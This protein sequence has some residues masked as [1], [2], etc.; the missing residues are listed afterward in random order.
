MIIGD[1]V[2]P[3]GIKNAL[4]YFKNRVP[5][6]EE[7]EKLQPVVLTQGEVPWDPCREDNNSLIMNDFNKGVVADA[8]AD[9]LAERQTEEATIFK[10]SNDPKEQDDMAEAI[11]S[12]MVQMT[13]QSQK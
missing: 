8:E 10:V 7:I 2:V 13:Q 5:T 12:K 6:D 4:L 11:Y 3:C 1:E 9:A